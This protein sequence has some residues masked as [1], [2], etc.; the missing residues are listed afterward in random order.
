MNYLAH[1]LRFL[2]DPWSLAGACLPDWLRVI[3]RRAR[4]HLPALDAVPPIDDIDQR[5][6]RGV[7]AHHDDDLRFHTH[8]HFSTLTDETVR[9]LRTLTPDPRFRASTVGHILVEMLLDAALLERVPDSGARFYAALATLDGERIATFARARTARPLELM[10]PL[11]ERFTMARFIF[12]YRDDT[13]VQ[14][15]MNGVLGR[16]GLPH[17]PDGFT[18]VVREARPRV[19]DAVDL[20]VAADIVMLRT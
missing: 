11:L 1:S 2:D 15:A 13:G 6:D 9:A 5:L 4:V 19:A 7:R 16:T 10:G 20:L 18:D 8:L 17:V 3:D 14:R 12:G